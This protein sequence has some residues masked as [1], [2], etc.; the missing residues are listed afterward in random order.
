M[1]RDAEHDASILMIRSIGKASR[2]L[3]RCLTAMV[4]A[5]F[6]T[7]SI[8]CSFQ[9]KWLLWKWVAALL[10][11]SKVLW[12]GELEN[13]FLY[14]EFDRNHSILYLININVTTICPI[15]NYI[16]I[17]RWKWCDVFVRGTHNLIKETVTVI[18]QTLI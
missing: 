16:L 14:S 8:V 3:I 13:C 6:T 4:W 1:T 15:Q 5:A 18:C 7:G 2:I 12:F 10:L 9:I 17:K 11:L